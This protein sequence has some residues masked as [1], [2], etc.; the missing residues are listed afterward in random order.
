[1]TKEEFRDLKPGDILSCGLY[2]DCENFLVIYADG[3]NVS[4][5]KT[6]TIGCPEL[7]TKVKDFIKVNEKG[8]IVYEN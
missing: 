7:W 5:V 2:S 4:V 8:K 1:M 3:K 6:N